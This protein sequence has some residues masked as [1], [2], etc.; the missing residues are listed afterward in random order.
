MRYQIGNVMKILLL[1][2]LTICTAVILFMSGC[3]SDVDV[4]YDR[5]LQRVKAEEPY[6]GFFAAEKKCIT[7]V[8]EDYLKAR[9]DFFLGIRTCEEEIDEFMDPFMEFC[10]NN[11]LIK[12][13]CEEEWEKTII[14][15]SLELYS[16][17]PIFEYNAKNVIAHRNLIYA[18]YANKKLALDLFLP[19]NGLEKP[20]PCIVCVHG[21]GWFVNRRIWFEPFAKYLADQGFAAVTIDYRKLPAV[22]IKDIVYDTK[23]AIR[24]VRANA[25][26]YG[27][28]PDKIGAIGASA[29]AHLV[30]LAGTTADMP[31]LEGNGGNQDQSSALQAVVGIATPAFTPE[32]STDR[33][34][35]YGLSPEVMRTLSPYQN[36]T[37]SSAPLFLINGTADETVPPQNSQDMFNKYTDAGAYV[38][39]KW[40]PDEGHGF[41]EGND[42]AIKLASEFFKK[43]LVK[44]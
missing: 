35:R 37:K 5:F 34:E 1:R 3:Q 28:N 24:W 2:F 36:I 23:A 4:A 17:K 19:N 6:I 11:N 12:T 8:N 44:K 39:L 20:L 22:A 21:G 26:Q 15:L 25:H 10:R 27:I 32:S 18:K 29:G 33:A 7:N 40:I 41:Y 9:R 16:N 30:A 14:I 38:E 43:I 13:G 31:Q 42:R